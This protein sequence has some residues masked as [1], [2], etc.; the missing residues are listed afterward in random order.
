MCEIQKSTNTDL[1]VISLKTD[2]FENLMHYLNLKCKGIWGVL[3]IH[4]FPVLTT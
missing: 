2:L 1:A 4:L 3:A